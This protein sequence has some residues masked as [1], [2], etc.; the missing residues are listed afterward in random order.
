RDKLVT[1]VQTC[2]LP[3]FIS[4]KKAKPGAAEC[5]AELVKAEDPSLILYTSDPSDVQGW[6]KAAARARL[7]EHRSKGQVL[8]YRIAS[9]TSL[10][11]L[12]G[13]HCPSKGLLS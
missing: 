7:K 4:S 12:V 5:P 13:G 3:I 2:A 1:G 6:E 11:S 9:K 10:A 8:H